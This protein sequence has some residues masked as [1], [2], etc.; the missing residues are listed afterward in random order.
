MAKKLVYESSVPPAPVYT[1][2]LLVIGHDDMLQVCLAPLLAKHQYHVV[3][4]H[5]VRMALTILSERS[6]MATLINF[7][8]TEPEANRICAIVREKS[9]VPIVMVSPNKRIHESV[10]SFEAGADHYL[11]MPFA[12]QELE[13]RILATQRR[14]KRNQPEKYCITQ[15]EFAL[16]PVK[17]E[18]RIKDAVIDLTNN[19]S[20]LLKYLVRNANQ[21]I[22]TEDLLHFVWGCNANDDLSLVRTTIHRLRHKIE[23]DPTTPKYLKTIF[24]LGY[25]FSATV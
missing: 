23:I 6:V 8:Q 21:V 24:G 19:E 9:T 10:I 22:R 25:R 5:T 12:V 13:A 17:Q 15:G 14:L 3:I 1:N 16:D 20:K 7:N 2:D 18:L 11:V 4:A